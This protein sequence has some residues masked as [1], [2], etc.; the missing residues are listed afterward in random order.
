SWR[1]SRR[2]TMTGRRSRAAFPTRGRTSTS[3]RSISSAPK[4]SRSWAAAWEISADSGQA[5]K[6]GYEATKRARFAG[7]AFFLAASRCRRAGGRARQDGLRLFDDRRHGG[8]LL[9]GEGDRRV[10][11]QRHRRRADLYLVG[12]R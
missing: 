5:R 8:R 7:G 2:S 6:D 9:D 11:A 10:R 12:S 3:S 4:G 1:K